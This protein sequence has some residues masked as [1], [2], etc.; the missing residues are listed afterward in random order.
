MDRSPAR[1]LFIYYRIASS[2]ARAARGVVTAFQARLCARHPG[3]SARLLRRPEEHLGQQTWMEIYAHT[4]TRGIDDALAA[5][6]EREAS[7]LAALLQGT[8]HV[9]VFVACAS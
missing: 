9:E 5:D 7:A 1:E 8:R 3:L 4:A 6:I 2:Q